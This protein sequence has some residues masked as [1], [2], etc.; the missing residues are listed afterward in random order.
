[1][2]VTATGSE[3]KMFDLFS[4]GDFEVTKFAGFEVKTNIKRRVS[5]QGFF[6]E[7][8]RMCVVFVVLGY[9]FK[10]GFSH[11]SCRRF[12]RAQSFPQP[13]QPVNYGHSS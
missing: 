6:R 9:S 7:H 10:Q 3:I 2:S 4:N 13:V 1:M 5:I 12:L 11:F 8:E